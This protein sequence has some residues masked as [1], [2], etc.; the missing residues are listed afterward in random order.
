V[1]EAIANPTPCPING[2]GI[3]VYRRSGDGV[4]VLLVHPAAVSGAD[5]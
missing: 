3:L 2:A 5:V 4:E 1:I